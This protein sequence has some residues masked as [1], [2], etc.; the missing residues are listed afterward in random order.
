MLAAVAARLV[1]RP[2]GQ[3]VGVLLAEDLAR[4]RVDGRGRAAQAY[5]VGATGGGPYV[6][7]PVEV[8]GLGRAGER[9]GAGGGGDG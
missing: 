6:G 4:G 5:R 3:L 9:G 2:V 7:Q 1:E 8:A